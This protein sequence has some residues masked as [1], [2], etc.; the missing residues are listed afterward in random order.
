V[1]GRGPMAR[2]P[3]LMGW[4]RALE[5]LLS[6]NDI[7]GDLAERYRYVDRALPDGELDK[8]FEEGKPLLT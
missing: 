1:P 3:R 6:G 5:I 8:V 7:N 2:L 4:G